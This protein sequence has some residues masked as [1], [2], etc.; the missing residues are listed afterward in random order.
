M[1]KK[2]MRKMSRDTRDEIKKRAVMAVR[3]LGHSPSE[4]C[5][6]FGVTRSRLY[7]WLE[8]YDKG[9][10]RALNSGKAPG[11]EPKLNPESLRKLA[12]LLR[13]ETPEAFGH[14][15]ALWTKSLVA[16]I[17][18]SEFGV[19][20][21]ISSVGRVLRSIG[22]SP[23]KPLHRAQEQDPKKVRKWLSTTFKE[24][25]ADARAVRASVFFGDEAN[26]RSDH[27][28]GRTWAPIGK[29]PIIRVSG[30]PLKVNVISA[31]SRRGDLRFALFEGRMNAG[32]FIEFLGKLMK[33]R[34]RPIFLIVDNSPVHRSKAVAEYVENFRGKLRLF[35]LPPY[36][37]ELNPD[38]L[39]WNHI[40]THGVD[41]QAI[42]S[43][44][45]FR[46]KIIGEM[47]SL[48]KRPAMVMK[49]F[50]SPSTSYAA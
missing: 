7:D 39:V 33:G 29:T 11:A 50:R 49:F 37:P 3:K 25:V 6:T 20:L 46:K 40:K 41:R 44:P 47:R 30:T 43:K 42:K 10:Q 2:D 26:I 8:R 34:R 32:K 19:K 12:S 38:E 18:K 35:F 48:Q 9:G 45:S 22:F 13:N 21:S 14:E 36:S 17:I 16:S 15:E 27:H 31:I 5:K 23:Q 28:A 1:K 24:I 4:V